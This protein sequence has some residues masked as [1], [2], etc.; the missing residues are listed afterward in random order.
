[1]SDKTSKLSTDILLGSLETKT[2]DAYQVTL[3]LSKISTN[4][5]IL[6]NVNSCRITKS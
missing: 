6:R 1:M 3:I 2:A 4:P 5:H